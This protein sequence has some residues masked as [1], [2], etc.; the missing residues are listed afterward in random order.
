MRSFEIHSI[1]HAS[2]HRFSSIVLDFLRSDPALRPFQSFESSWE[3]L[4]SALKARA[5]HPV[6]RPVLIE[7]LKRQYSELDLSVQEAP[8]LEVLAEENCFT[9][10]TAHQPNLFTGYLYFIYKIQ[11]TICLTE[12][13]R[14][15]HPNH[16]FV[17]V[18]YLGTED[19]DLEELGQCWY[20]DERYEWDAQGQ[21]GAVGRMENRGIPEVWDQIRKRLGPPGP[22]LDQLESWV[23]RSYFGHRTVAGALRQWVHELFGGQGLVVLDADDSA[24]KSRFAPIMAVEMMTQSSEPRV[25]AAADAM[26][27]RY[28]S[29]VFPRP[30]NLFYLDEQ[31]R[32]RIQ[33][34][35]DEWVV[36][37]SKKR[38]TESQWREE[39][40][41]HP[42]RFSPNVILRPL[43]QETILPNLAFVGGGAEIAYW[44]QVKSVFDD[45]KVFFP[46]LILRQS[47][48]WIPERAFQRRKKLGLSVE[49]LFSPPSAL[50]KELVDRH[51][52]PRTKL[53]DP[54]DVLSS[55]A[56]EVKQSAQILDPSL[57]RALEASLKRMNREIQRMDK[58]IYRAQR[59]KQDQQIRQMKA[60]LDW[61]LPGGGLEERRRNFMEFYLDYGPMFFELVRKSIHPLGKVFSVIEEQKETRT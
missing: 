1:P 61:V 3:G 39:L 36:K 15:R 52:D 21:Q 32:E 16:H 57:L 40:A 56:A 11:H 29:Q 24:L 46:A 18:F 7:V 10:C 8:N 41:E 54:Q 44:M 6:D 30:I 31:L 25:R 28:K 13:L 22:W 23:R 9:V 19:N 34:D 4:E 47:I 58:K 17:P 26:A 55:W 51:S 49:S 42:E 60:L 59:R 5:Q 53:P 35:G 27:D 45:H 20:R 48:N 38:W 37:G 33:K 43:Y 14:A 2:T 50:I 12:A